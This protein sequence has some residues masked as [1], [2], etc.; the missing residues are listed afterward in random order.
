[1]DNIILIL[2]VKYGF[3]VVDGLVILTSVNFDM[4]G[5]RDDILVFI[6][7]WYLILYN[8]YNIY[9]SFAEVV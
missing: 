2:E 6:V 4:R 1:M 8:F 7:I 9:F 3:V 5:I